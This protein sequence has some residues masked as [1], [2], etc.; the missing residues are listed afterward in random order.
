[1]P[2]LK[3]TPKRVTLE[4][5]SFVLITTIVFGIVFKAYNT[6]GLFGFTT[7]MLQFKLSICVVVA[8]VMLIAT[9]WESEYIYHKYKES[10]VEKETMQQLSIQ[11]EFES[12]KTR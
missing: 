1:M 5:V 12:L 9:L 6:F 8:T 2:G 11:N 4:A 3:Q 7:S 10:F